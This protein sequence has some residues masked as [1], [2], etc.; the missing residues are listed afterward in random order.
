[1]PKLVVSSDFLFGCQQQQIAPKLQFYPKKLA[2]KRYKK[3]DVTQDMVYLKEVNQDPGYAF[4]LLVGEGLM[5]SFGLLGAGV[6]NPEAPVF[7]GQLFFFGRKPTVISR[8]REERY[9]RL[10]VRGFHILF[11]WILGQHFSCTFNNRG[12][13]LTTTA[14]VLMGLLCL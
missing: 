8:W 11:L 14:S 12:R 4:Q 13:L 7:V 2:F 5:L 6:E 1:M 9:T 10:D 3:A